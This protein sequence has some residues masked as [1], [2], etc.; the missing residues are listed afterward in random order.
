MRL[1]NTFKNGCLYFGMSKK[2]CSYIFKEEVQQ[3]T[4]DI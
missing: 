3:E 2:N 4:L 1:K